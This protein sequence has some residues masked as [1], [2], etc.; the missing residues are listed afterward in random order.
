MATLSFD[1]EYPVECD[2]DYW[3]TPNPDDAF[4]QPPGKPSVITS[5]VLHLKLFEIMGLSLR[6]LYA[7]K[8]SK[9]LLG[10]TQPDSEQRIVAEFDSA[11]NHWKE[12][13]P[14]F[15]T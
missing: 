1:V 12:S 2:D 9:V 15:R 7:T 4:R 5:F 6:T 10:M 3:E 13:I 8:K 11:L 14:P